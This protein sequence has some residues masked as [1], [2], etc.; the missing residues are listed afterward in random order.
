M[1]SSDLDEFNPRTDKIV[2]PDDKPHVF[3]RMQEAEEAANK[4]LDGFVKYIEG[5][6]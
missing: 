5:K 1:C 4:E 3:L 6:L 2:R